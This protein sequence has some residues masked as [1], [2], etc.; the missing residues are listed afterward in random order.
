M[1][2][3]NLNLLTLMSLAIIVTG[4]AGTNF[5]NQ[6]QSDKLDLLAE[7][8]FMRYNTNRLASL[9]STKKGFITQALI[10]CHQNKFI[11]G[12]TLL[13][14][15]MQESKANPFYWNAIGTCYTLSK[16]L[17]KGAFYYE[18]GL[19][20]ARASNKDLPD[21][22]KKIAESVLSNN[23]GLIHLNYKRY[24]EAF[25]SFK[26]SNSLAPNFFTP[27]FNLAQLY[28]EFNENNKALDLLKKLESKNNEDIDLLYSLALI[29]FRQNDLD[30]S[31]VY[32]NKIQKDYLNRADIVGL[33]A[34]NLMRKNRFVEAK[35]ILE[36]RLFA[37][38]YNQ[39]NELI[40]DE[41]N[42]KIKELP[43]IAKNIEAQK[44]QEKQ[45][46]ENAK[47]VPVKK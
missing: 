44:L 39:R 45:V 17:T 13:E 46:E 4:C 9:E 24:D 26:K 31:Y 32:I 3:K 23:I 29:Y 19:E 15:K 21:S 43:E 14:E 5:S 12:L 2:K 22:Q 6:I 27:E 38:E 47:K 34:Y 28:L 18:L 35:A 1:M 36:K 11:K 10:A 42:Q 16:N 33:Y 41:V 25:D 40:L 30:N 20:A 8:S 7:E 37:N